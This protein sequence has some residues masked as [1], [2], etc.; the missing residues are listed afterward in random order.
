MQPDGAASGGQPRA[1]AQREIS[2][3]VSSPGD[4]A[5]EREAVGRVVERLHTIYRSVVTIRTVRWEH[6]YY[7]ADQTFQQQI[8]NPQSCDIVV[9]IFWSRIGSE[10][11]PGFE[12][13]PDG[14]PY[15]SGTIYE[16]LKALDAKSRRGLPDVLVYR[17]TQDVATPVGDPRL[18]A[19]VQA[20]LDAVHSFWSERFVSEQGHFLAG[21]HTFHTTDD[22]E[23][24]FEAHLRKWLTDRGLLT[25][26]VVW[27]VAERGSPFRGLEPFGAKH[28]DVMFGRS[29]EIERGIALV[30][31]TLS[32]GCAFLLITGESGTGK[33]SLARAGLIPHVMRLSG[34]DGSDV[35]RLGR[36]RPAKSDPLLTLAEAL[37]EALPELARSDYSNPAVLRALLSHHD[38]TITLPVSRTLAR[39]ADDWR[40]THGLDRPAHG[41]VLLLVDQLEELFAS[42]IS[43]ADREMFAAVCSELARSG[44]VV[45]IATL[46]A[47]AYPLFIGCDAFRG[48]K[49]QGQTLDVTTPR[50]A[51]I[52]EIV[53]HS[54]EAAGFTFDTDEVSGKRLSALL[55]AA[56][57]GRDA[58]PL[59]Q[60]A[61]QRLYDAMVARFAAAGRG[62]A[63]VEPA[64]L[65]LRS[66]DYA[67]FGGLEGALSDA[68]EHAFGQLD[69]SAQSRLPRLAR[70][71]L[72]RGERGYTLQSA[73][74]HAF[75]D[76]PPALRLIEAL[77]AARILVQGDNEAGI[78]F[79]HE[80][81]QRSWERLAKIVAA[82][83][84]FYRIRA[85][86]QTAYLR[87]VE[88]RARNESSDDFLIPSGV[89]IAEAEKA[90]QD[91]P[92]DFS[93]EELDYIAD[94]GR[95]ARLR[96]RLL[97]AAVVAFAAL[98][99][100]AGLFAVIAQRR[101][102][103][104]LQ[105]QSKI[106]SVIA[107]HTTAPDRQLNTPDPMFMSGDP[108]SGALLALEGLPYPGF[109]GN[110]PRSPDLE[111][112]LYDALLR[113]RETTLIGHTGAVNVA[114]F[115]PDGQSVVT[116]SAD[117]T[118]R[119]WRRTGLIWTSTALAGHTGAINA[120]AFS[121]DGLRLVTVSDDHTARL[122]DIA[123]SPPTAQQLRGHDA[124]VVHVAF[125]PDGRYFVTT[126]DDNTARLWDARLAH[127]SSIVLRGHQDVV[128]FATFSPDS[129]SL[130]TTSWDHTLRLWDISEAQPAAVVLDAHTDRI[131]SAAFS[132]DGNRIVTASNDGTARLWDL[133][134]AGPVSTVLE[135]HSFPV[136]AAAFS[137]DGSRLTTVSD[138]HTAHLWNLTATPPTAVVMRGHS[139]A[140]NFV[141]F[142]PDSRHVA[143]ASN[144]RTIRLWDLNG[145]QIVVEGHTGPIRSIA[146]SPDGRH[147]ITGSRDRTARIWDVVGALRT[148]VVLHGHH[149]AVNVVSFSPDG[150]LLATG[151]EDG[152]ARLWRVQDETPAPIVLQGHAGSVNSAAF[153]PDGRLLATASWDRTVRLWDLR[154]VQG[155]PVVLRGY[156]GSVNAVAFSPDGKTLATASDD[157]LVRLWNVEK[158]ETAARVLQGHAGPVSSVAFSPDG[159]WLASASWDQTVRLWDLTAAQSTWVELRGHT[160]AI[161]AA[162]FSPDGRWLVSASHDQTA[163]LWDL[164]AR[165]PT[166]LVLRGHTDSVNAAAFSP[167]GRHLFTVSSDH[168]TRMW[169]FSGDQ[170]A[171]FVLE[172]HSRPVASIAFA[173]DGRHFA[174]S[175]WDTTVRVWVHY[176]ALNDLIAAVFAQ[177]Q[178]C[179][180]AAQ[181]ATFGLAN[182]G[183]GGDPERVPALVVGTDGR[184]RCE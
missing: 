7:T 18:R 76:D 156:D 24:Q 181:R 117:G 115:S 11:P 173:P 178:R 102:T 16:L 85:D 166:S 183:S 15:P 59:L 88:A 57:E 8:D 167:D 162:V 135:R 118:A 53:T 120:A 176:P 4:V 114:A 127:P 31:R 133:R 152:T 41:R 168:N 6:D 93:K 61:L 177:T 164:A 95:R 110:R 80:A 70:A 163:R 103:A 68:A 170:L 159:R 125:S 39:V 47:D 140:V 182:A 116:A 64:E 82:H 19:V 52:A 109:G 74:Q 62:L 63:A 143:T 32:T 111:M 23:K 73:N 175:S 180:T 153:S 101:G 172:G 155:A 160:G 149:G 78:R 112:A 49:A 132:P 3:F 84:T 89:P 56:A 150:R 77:T 119:L 81:V 34:A 171:S 37:F 25:R 33:S 165:P 96:Q 129:R 137:P 5:A 50:H 161:N 145:S 107:E 139:D 38:A 141:V 29:A 105:A 44:S 123:A 28:E 55:I 144:D 174:T 138:D 1:D 157:H 90:A 128:N 17:K 12:L 66:K 36:M 20:Q 100:V 54:A 99:A 22:F 30:Q 124:P 79:A 60:F 158:P 142:A 42:D 97:R 148:S 27:P 134:G 146:F 113:V 72:R 21:Y 147:L 87:W 94:S 83:Q 35:W 45:L 126:S 108:T 75:V 65:V 58:L 106:L 2:L 98:F 136:N 40:A 10:L 91:Y 154:R 184:P 122:W 86:V 151:S 71:L 92:Q 169:D 46:R 14:R 179:L 48:L 69:E 104:A 67:D 51:E 121:P 43:E 130:L 13:M 131:G 9:S 26:S